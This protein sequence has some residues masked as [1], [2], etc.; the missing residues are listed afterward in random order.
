MGIL[1]ALFG[2]RS[3]RRYEV[4]YIGAA[5]SEVLGYS[6]AEMYLTQ[7]ALRSVV[8]FI[9]G[10]VASIPLKCYIRESDTSRRRD[11]EGILPTLLRFP[12]PHATGHELMLA[13]VSDL[14]LYGFALWV[15]I[16]SVDMPSGWTIEQI[17]SSWVTEVKSA[18]GFAPSSYVVDNPH[19][20]KRAEIPAADVLRF[21]DYSP[22]GLG[23]SSPVSALKQVLAEQVN[24]WQYRNQV[25][26]NG[27]RVSQVIERPAGVPW[28]PA[29]RDRFA[30]SWK[31]RF[32]GNGGTDSGGT[33]ILED[34]MRLVGNTFN[35]KE[36]EWAEATKLAREDVAAV[37]HIN[38]SLIWHTDA[39]T[40][41]SAK[42]NARAL[43]AE[44]LQPILDM[45]SE[46]INSF[47]LPKIG[48]DPREYVEF[49][50]SKKLEASFEER[51]SVLQSAVGAP[52]MTRNEARAANNLPM[53]EGGDELVVPLNVVTGGLA[54]PNDTA[55]TG[56]YD[57]SEPLL[58]EAKDEPEARI[59][60]APHAHE[61]MEAASVLRAFAKRQR[62]KVLPAIDRAKSKGIK[63]DGDWPVWWDADRWDRELSEDLGKLFSSLIENG[64][65][66]TLK[67]LGIDADSFDISKAEAYIR[68]MAEGKAKA[69]NN[70]TYRELRKALD[71][72]ISEDAEGATTEGVFDKAEGGRA[73]NAGISFATAAVGFATIEAV[74]QGA[75]ASRYRRM[76]T[77]IVKSGNPRPEHLALD[78]ETVDLEGEFSNG[79][80]FPGDHVLTPDES[81]GCQCQVE[82]TIWRI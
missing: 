35:A 67:Q 40:Y 58:K 41:A 18:T 75:P 79:A 37:Y 2:G 71:D 72:D 57:A 65:R 26:K 33:P 22:H 69:F 66:R 68:K 76:K 47:L 24:A 15:V 77:W 53:V 9:A 60:A 49:D 20:G 5:A 43:Y 21:G 19:T 34:G 6:V 56:G 59:K 62:K 31:N 50:L 11:T 61:S 48:A 17:P 42:E 54:S 30:E 80:K 44:T 13:T 7:P 38:P 23:S 14:K 29:D 12:N 82:I 32:S 52:W 1:D 73:D 46:R 70:V 63:A 78:G 81:C 10:N 4:R 64:A 28:D 55:P 51:A 39:Q 16:P 3:G 25:W 36:A 27:G 8:S 74:K 45:L